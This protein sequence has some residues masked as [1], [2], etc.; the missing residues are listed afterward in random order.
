MLKVSNSD[1]KW[2]LGERFFLKTMTTH[3]ESIHVSD[4]IS[5]LQIRVQEKLEKSEFITVEMFPFIA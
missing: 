3:N 4:L 1:T 5:L 2:L